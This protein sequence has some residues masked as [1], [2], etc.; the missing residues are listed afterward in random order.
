MN[1]SG[2]EDFERWLERELPMA[3]ASG[4]GRG[5]RV[6]PAAYRLA[7]SG[8]E[9][10]RLPRGIRGAA[11][12]AVAVL[13]VLV[14]GA[15]AMAAAGGPG[16]VSLGRHVVQVVVSCQAAGVQLGPGVGQCAR[17]IAHPRAEATQTRPASSPAVTAAA[18]AGGLTRTPVPAPGPYEDGPSRPAPPVEDRDAIPAHPGDHGQGHGQDDRGHPH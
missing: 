16:P 11:S 8:R 3:V 5:S 6:A 15:A 4:R 17:D 18:R 12:I 10:R 14:G 1:G 9:R 7:V 2:G 13:A